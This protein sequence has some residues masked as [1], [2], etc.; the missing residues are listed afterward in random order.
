MAV[1]GFGDAAVAGGLVGLGVTGAAPRGWMPRTLTGC[2][3]GVAGA[4]AFAMPMNVAGE[5]MRV[6]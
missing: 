6:G 4:V 2:T 5:S 3:G 1:V